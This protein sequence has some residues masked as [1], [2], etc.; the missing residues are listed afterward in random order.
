MQNYAVVLYPDKKGLIRLMNLMSG[1]LMI[2]FR[3]KPHITLAVF[4][5]RSELA[6]KYAYRRLAQSLKPAKLYYHNI[7]RSQ[8]DIIYA[9]SKRSENL[10]YDLHITDEAL[11][12]RFQRI[13][14]DVSLDE[15]IPLTA[16]AYKVEMVDMNAYAWY[17][18]RVFREF[19]CSA[20]TAALV[21][22]DPYT[23]LYV[24]KLRRND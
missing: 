11:F 24:T 23:E 3:I 17:V 14:G 5:S 4:G 20:S 15:W 19:E 1:S 10:N 22:L 16:V 8:S 7:Q 18:N 9:E 2:D 6:A 13:A 12:P 21:R